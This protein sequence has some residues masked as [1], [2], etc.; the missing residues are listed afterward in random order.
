MVRLVALFTRAWIEIKEYNAALNTDS[1]ALFTRAWIEIAL[2]TMGAL[3]MGSP[4]SRGRGLKYDEVVIDCRKDTSP[5]S[6]GR[7][8][9]Y[10]TCI[11]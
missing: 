7:G 9:K 2:I 5:S 4:S 10:L 8:L 11:Y 3:N 1:V 6:R